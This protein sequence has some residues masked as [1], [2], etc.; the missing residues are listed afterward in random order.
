VSCAVAAAVAQNLLHETATITNITILMVG[1][2]LIVL[3]LFAYPLSAF[4][5]PLAE[6][7]K[8]TLMRLSAQATQYHRLA[9]RKLIGSNVVAESS[10]DAEQPQ[11]E[12]A[13]P[14]KQF[15][16]TRKLSPMLLSRSALLPVSAAA[17]LPFVI[18]ASSRV[19]FKEVLSLVK[20]LLLL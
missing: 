8:A 20:K 1:W 3:G 4:C 13:D 19:P 16:T 15:E 2:L 7:K 12:V 9:E 18:V 14:S 5:R 17:L 6:L 10:P 11:E